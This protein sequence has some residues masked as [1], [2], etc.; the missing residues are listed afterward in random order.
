[1][2]TA[3]GEVRHRVHPRI[4]PWL[5]F[6]QHPYASSGVS[7]NGCTVHP[8]GPLY[9]CLYGYRAKPG[10][11]KKTIVF[12]GFSSVSRVSWRGDFSP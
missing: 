9:G 1:M 10:K 12:I 7:V 3:A 6:R 8:Q 5:G 2:F 4:P 11:V